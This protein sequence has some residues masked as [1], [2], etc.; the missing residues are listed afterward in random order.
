MKIILTYYPLNVAWNHGISLLANICRSKEIRTLIVPIGPVF[1]NNVMKHQPDYVGFSFVTEE[2]YFISLSFV[3]EVRKMGIKTIAGGVY[4]KMGGHIDMRMFDHVCRGEGERLPDFL[5]KG[6]VSALEGYV[7]SDIDKL[8][9]CDYTGVTGFEFNRPQYGYSFL[10][11]IKILSYS[12]SRGCPFKCNFCETQLWNQPVRIKHRIAQELDYLMDK[13]NPDMFYITDELMP[14]YRKDWLKQWK[15]NKYPFF[16]MIRADIKPETLNHLIDDGLKFCVFGIESGDEEYRNSILNKGLKD[17]DIYKTVSILQN[18]N[19]TYSPF[20]MSHTPYET[21]EIRAKTESMKKDIGGWPVMFKYTDIRKKVFCI[22]DAD[23]DKYCEKTGGNKVAFLNNLN[24]LETHC[25]SNDH[26]FLVYEVHPDNL[27]IQ[28]IYGDGKYWFNEKIPELCRQ[29]GVKKYL[30]HVKRAK[31]M[32]R[33]YGFK[34]VAEL[35]EG[36]VI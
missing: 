32:K 6:D 8:P 26:G 19:I 11:G 24:K 13:Y 2:D 21:D 17:A 36:E 12:S 28:E 16:G 5:L 27:L 18:R 20:Y 1:I 31:A 35:I 14:Y 29:R 25:I 7:H 10:N 30:G 33:A 4:A 22:S 15:G 34:S 3:K 23:I 9:L